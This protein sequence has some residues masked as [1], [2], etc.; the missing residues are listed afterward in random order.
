MLVCRNLDRLSLSKYF[1]FRRWEAALALST[2]STLSQTCKINKMTLRTSPNLNLAMLLATIGNTPVM[3]KRTWI[4]MV[5]ES[6][7]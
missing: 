3:R 4:S 1:K 6:P 5:E 7:E 2:Q